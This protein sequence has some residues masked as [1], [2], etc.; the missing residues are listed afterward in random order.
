MSGDME[1]SSL[2]IMS[3]WH[4]YIVNLKQGKFH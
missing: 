2:A 3:S 1:I 4:G